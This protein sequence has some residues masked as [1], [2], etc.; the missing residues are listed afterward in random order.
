MFEGHLGDGSSLKS[1]MNRWCVLG[2]GG[3][4]GIFTL[5]DRA[6]MFRVFLFYSLCFGYRI[7]FEAQRYD[8]MMIWSRLFEIFFVLGVPFE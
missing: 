7:L 5:I 3:T 4:M 8:V 6:C 1:M 2:L